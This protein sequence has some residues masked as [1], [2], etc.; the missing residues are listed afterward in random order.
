MTKLS[1]SLE[2]TTATVCWPGL[3]GTNSIVCSSSWIQRRDYSSV[4][5]STTASDMCCGTD[6]T[7]FR[8]SS[9]SSSSCA[10][11]RSKRFTDLHRPTSPICVDQWRRLSADKD[12]LVVSPTVTHFGT[13]SF[14]AAGPEAW[15]CLTADIRTSDCHFLKK[16]FKDIFVLLTIITDQT[17]RAFVIDFPCYGPWQILSVVIIIIINCRKIRRCKILYFLS[18]I[19]SKPNLFT[20]GVH[21][22]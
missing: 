4:P 16:G 21:V 19:F 5:R 9:A 6:S 14:A 22:A 11:W 15:N 10:C 20:L 7:G 1:S 3:H 13:R 2:L 8:Y 17:R 18:F 12:D